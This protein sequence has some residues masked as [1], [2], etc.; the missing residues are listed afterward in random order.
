[1]AI[2]PI[3]RSALPLL[4][5]I[6]AGAPRLQA[7][8]PLDEGTFE[9][10]VDGRPAGTEEFSIRQSGSGSGA[11]T[12]ATGRVRLR[13]PD[14]ALD[15]TPRLRGSGLGAHPVS[16]QVEVGGSAPQ[17]IVGRV[18]EGRFSAR[19]V[20]T[21]GE[22]L[23]EYVASSGAVVLEDGVAHHYFFLGQRLRDGEVP[24]LIP[25]ENRQVVA[26][27]QNRGE[28]RVQIGGQ[29]VDAYRLLVQLQP[30][31]ERHVWLD[32]LNRVLRVEICRLSG[33]RWVTTYVAVRTAAPS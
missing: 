23:R 9:V 2:H 22:Q 19:I 24:V 32:A 25:R 8:A 21:T 27:V 28:E 5:A 31:E 26:R 11:E 18:G 10:S 3:L 29:G 15:L 4:L 1:M 12:I 13:L 16:Y 17:R 7:Q 14:G 20:T 30:G 6:A 33:G